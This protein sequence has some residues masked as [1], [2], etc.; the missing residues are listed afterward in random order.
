MKDLRIFIFFYFVL[1]IGFSCIFAV[2][3]VGNPNFKGNEYWNF[4]HNAPEGFGPLPMAE[5][6]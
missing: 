3:G 5:Y 4:V 2:I 6:D 1:I